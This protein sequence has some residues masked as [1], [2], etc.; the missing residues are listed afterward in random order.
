MTHIKAFDNFFLPISD[1]DTANEFYHK[2]LGLAVKFD[3]R[4]KGMMA[5]TVG[6]SEPAII[7]QKSKNT[8][9]A[10]W[11]QVTDVP[12]AIV[13]LESRGIIFSKKPFEIQTGLAAEFQDPF[14]NRFVI[15][16]YSKGKE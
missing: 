15:T 9:P 3:M 4:D 6:E 14:G 12:D 7:I 5:F 11:L 8:A 2:Q 10:I 13:D 1:F 16:D